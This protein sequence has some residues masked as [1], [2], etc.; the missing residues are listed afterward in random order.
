L[1]VIR[2]KDRPGFDE[3]SSKLPRFNGKLAQD[4]LLLRKIMGVLSSYAENII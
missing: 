1:E 3:I 2:A 4:V